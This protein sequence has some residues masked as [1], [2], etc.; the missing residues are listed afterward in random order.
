MLLKIGVVLIDAER[1]TSSD[2]TSS[3]TSSNNCEWLV[4]NRRLWVIMGRYLVEDFAAGNVS[5]YA[6]TT[7]LLR[8]SVVHKVEAINVVIQT[9][10]ALKC[11]STIIAKATLLPFCRRLKFPVPFLF[12]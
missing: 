5:H 9:V 10:F 7:D 4:V 11:R 3:D 2:N 6:T 8:E 12:L 1:N